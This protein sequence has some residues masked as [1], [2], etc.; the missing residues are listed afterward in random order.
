MNSTFKENS[1]VEVQISG[2]DIDRYA[3]VIA[4][5]NV[6]EARKLLESLCSIGHPDVIRWNTNREESGDLYNVYEVVKDFLKDRECGHVENV[7][8]SK[9]QFQLY[10]DIDCGIVTINN[11]NLFNHAS[12]GIDSLAMFERTINHAIA[13]ANGRR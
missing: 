2:D 7:E 3:N 13:I 5:C 9:E 11:N 4:H 12:N 1:L 6:S 8:D 10:I